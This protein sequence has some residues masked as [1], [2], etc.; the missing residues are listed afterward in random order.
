MRRR[1]RLPDGR[2][3]IGAKR[4]QSSGQCKIINLRGHGVSFLYPRQPR[5]R[6]SQARR[7]PRRPSAAGMERC[8]RPAIHALGCRTSPRR[9]SRRVCD[10]DVAGLLPTLP[11]RGACLCGRGRRR[12]LGSRML[13]WE[14][15]GHARDRRLGGLLYGL[16]GG[17]G[18]GGE[19]N[20]GLHGAIVL[21]QERRAT[22]RSHVLNLLAYRGPR[23]EER[24]PGARGGISPPGPL[25][26]PQ[27]PKLHIRT[28]ARRRRLLPRGLPPGGAPPGEL[29]N[30]TQVLP[31]N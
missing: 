2:C 18:G 24:L 4:R 26:F 30:T 8:A 10:R 6:R 27:A 23:V 12:Q 7:D 1:C 19:E 15:R 16:F 5:A 28:R 25:G 13:I 20:G 11:A 21:Q 29:G 22:C 14:R 17:M 3:Q 9:R 31:H